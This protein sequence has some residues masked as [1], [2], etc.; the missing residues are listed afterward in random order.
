MLVKV[1]GKKFF[2]VKFKVNGKETTKSLGQY[3]DLSLY[4]ARIKHQEIKNDLV[5][6]INPNAK[7]IKDEDKKSFV[8]FEMLAKEFLEFKN[9]N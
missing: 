2:K 5:N 6:G 3:P 9:M 4:N 7:V 8:T 1:N